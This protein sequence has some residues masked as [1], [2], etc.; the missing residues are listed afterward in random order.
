MM[1]RIKALLMLGALVLYF[2]SC[3]STP[4]LNEHSNPKPPNILF[5]AID[6]LRTDLGA[7]GNKVVQSPNLDKLASEGAVF[8]NHFVQVPTCGPS[9]V[10][11][12]TGMRPRSRSEIRN[13]VAAKTIASLPESVK[14]ETFVHHLKRSG[15]YTA[16]IGKISHSA[17]G[18]IYGYN[19]QPS[20]QKELPHSW[21]EFL[22]DSGKWG[23]GWNAFFAYANGENRQSLKRQ[24]RPY[25]AGQ[26]VDLGYPDGLT[27]NLAIETLA[28]LKDKNEPFFLG[29]GFFKPHLPFTAPQKYWELYDP[30]DLQLAANPRLPKNVNLK[31][32]NRSGEFNQYALGEEKVNLKTQISEEY[33]R[34]LKHAYYACISYTDAQV[35]KLLQE[36][37]R[38]GLT[39]NTIIIVWSDHG[40]HLG[41]QHMYGKHALFDNALKSPLIVKLPGQNQTNTNIESITESVDIYPSII[42]MC[43]LEMPHEVDGKSFVD[44]L[45]NGSSAKEQIA[46]SYFREGI[47]MR[48]D[49]YRLTKYFRDDLP[50]V[51]LFDHQNDPHESINVA[52]QHPEIVELLMPILEAGNTGLFKEER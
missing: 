50:N 13:D 46:Y 12:L 26:V 16:G 43:G 7:Y 22:F 36:L 28:K 51:E 1:V 40:W 21:D 38:Q 42:E 32:I 31:S 10:C 25:E 35:G 15:Y 24:V 52:D 5:I 48:G 6:D 4:N 30:A 14:P 20:T 39:D 45:K 37:E 11:M 27:A 44:Q 2:I 19:E 41:E 17:D 29:V 9:R 47:S 33:A 23:T 8:M 3:S 49:R 34:K 18:L